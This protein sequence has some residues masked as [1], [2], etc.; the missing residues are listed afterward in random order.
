MKRKSFFVK[1]F[2]SY[3][4]IILLLSFLIFFL[5]F[6]IIKYYYINTL[7]NNLKNI[8]ETLK[9]K[10]T[11]LIVKKEID[12]IDP[13][14]KEIGKKIKT[15]ITV[16]SPEGVVWG[17]SEKDPEKMENHKYRPEVQEALKGKIG[18]SIRFSK[19]VRQNMLYV[20]LPLKHNNKILGI[21]RTS[22]F[23]KDINTLLK[24]LKIKILQISLIIS[25]FA[26][27]GA[28]F[29]SQS[30]SK[31]IKE[32]V[33]A[34][35][36]VANGNFNIKIFLKNEDE[37]K[38]LADSFNYMTSKIKDLFSE[39]SYEKEELN[40]IISSIEE[41]ILVL[42]KNGRIILANNSFKKITGTDSIIN[43]F[44]WE[45]LR[46]EAFIELIKNVREKQRN[47]V[48]EIELNNR[49]FLCSATSLKSKEE[50]V[51]VFHDI[52]E[53][54]EIEKMKR[55]FVANVSHELRTPLTAI[56][57]FVE[58]LLDEEKD[59]N[60]KHYLKI[61]QRHT[62]RLINIVKD[63]LLLSQLEERRSKLEIED[64]NLKRLLEDISKM[65]IEKIK[66]K[67]LKL[68]IE[69]QKDLPLVK[70]DPFKLE[71]MFI[72][73]IDNA[74]KYTDKGEIKISIEQIDN[75]IK[76]VVADT[77]IGISE[78]H[79]SRIFERFYVV[80]K[81]RSRRYGGTGLGLSIV[82]HVVLLHNGKIEVK[83]KKNKG[84]KFTIYLPYIR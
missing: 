47:F 63:L 10:I 23:L 35:R 11:P 37:I 50:I 79:L 18:K 53:I 58:T 51:L 36:E 67:K 29:F 68:K 8:G 15:R 12:S 72:N 2:T 64:V 62:D 43:K 60:K 5:S 39:L 16:I 7:T 57:G 61:I 40:S 25:I 69:I 66:Q 42:D 81:S 74:I 30:L 24:E 77:G 32:L 46:D 45:I 1:I 70:A 20:A 54:R 41:G 14:V 33:K 34:S 31:P 84:T 26:L 78:K 6:K 3:I 4:F 44:Y 13:T 80:D 65:F 19:T 59:L 38:E 17:D 9:L 21:L 56:K 27:L 52:T 82:K 48:K 71:Q 76:I 73:L 83:S 75:L 22:L 55:D 28:I 49:I